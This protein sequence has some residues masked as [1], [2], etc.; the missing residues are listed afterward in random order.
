LPKVTVDPPPRSTSVD[1]A[2]AYALLQVGKPYVRGK[3]GPSSF[4]CSGLVK[5]AWSAAGVTIPRT[6]GQQFAVTIHIDMR[7]ALPGDLIFYGQNGAQHVAMY[8]GFGLIVEAAN[9][10]KGVVISPISTPWHKYNFGGIGRVKA[11]L[12]PITQP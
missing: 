5:R 6:S 7:D 9:T 10:R 12:S 1:Q 2:I 4:D 8:I 11:P 3:T